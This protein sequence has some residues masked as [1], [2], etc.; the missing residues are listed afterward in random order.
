M[1]RAVKPWTGKTDDTPPTTAVKRRIVQRQNGICALTGHPFA[2]G[3]KIEYDHITPLWIGGKNTEANLQAVIGEAHKGKTKAEA[4]V[5]AKVNAITDR[6]L[7]ITAPKAKIASRPF[8]TRPK[9]PR[10]SKPMLPPLALY[11]QQIGE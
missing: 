6:H 9:P 1:P 11:R 7:G 8:Q 4:A 5:R 10:T 2:A 3:D